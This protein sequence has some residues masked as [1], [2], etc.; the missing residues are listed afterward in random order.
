MHQAL[1][2]DNSWKKSH[3]K[4]VYVTDTTGKNISK[5]SGQVCQHKIMTEKYHRCEHFGWLLM[6]NKC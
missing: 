3:E 4:N 5:E 6:V 2:Q 1:V